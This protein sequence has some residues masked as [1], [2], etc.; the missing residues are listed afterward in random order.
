MNAMHEFEFRGAIPSDKDAVLALCAKIWEGDDYIPMS[1]DSWVADRSGELALCLADGKIVG[2]ARLSWLGPGEAWLEGLRKDPDAGVTGVGTA[3]CRRFLRRLATARP[4]D[5]PLRYVRFSTYAGNA[6]SIRLNEALGFREIA[7]ASVKD[8]DRATLHNPAIR[9]RPERS[10]LVSVVR[11]PAL[12][13]PFVRASGWFGPLIHECWRSYPWSEE[14]FV[15][16]YLKAGRCLGLVEDGRLRAL[17][18]CLVHEEKGE[19][20][21]PFFDAEDWASAAVLL[22]AVADR[23]RGEGAPYIDAIV[24]PGGKRALR[25]LDA[26]GWRSWEYEGDYLVYELPLEILERY[27]DGGPR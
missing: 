25:L 22:G 19:G 2:L 7:R 16:R 1:F 12:A 24:P 4:D 15:E 20:T 10:S 5:P 8:L 23:L 21:L 27:A 3:L 26:C 17:A 18:A 14:F 13:L 9:S 11:D 6:A